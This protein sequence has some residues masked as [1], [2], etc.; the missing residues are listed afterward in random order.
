MYVSTFCGNLVYIQVYVNGREKFYIELQSKL[1]IN[2]IF[3]ILRVFVQ[4][5][6][7]CLQE[8]YVGDSEYLWKEDFLVQVMVYCSICF[9]LD[10]F[11]IVQ[12][13]FFIKVRQSIKEFS[14]DCRE[15][16]YFLIRF[17]GKI[18][19]VLLF[20]IGNF[21]FILRYIV[22]FYVVFY[23][24]CILILLL[25]NLKIIEFFD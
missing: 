22:Y 16:K 8:Y 20:V 18:Y 21:F 5:N 3:K 12:V 10:L 15:F 9:D 2:Y 24:I 25:N 13:V 14:D 19:K 17:R 1:R 11:S 4:K 6:C 23:C 7:F